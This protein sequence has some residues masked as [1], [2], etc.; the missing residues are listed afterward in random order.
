ML[1]EAERDDYDKAKS[2]LKNRFKSVDIAELRGLE[3]H[4]KQQESE[5]VEEL[6]ME[7]QRLGNLAF[8]TL[9]GQERDTFLSGPTGAL[10]A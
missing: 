10:E 8:P 6:G 3:F 1:P 5:T 2:A 9:H 4:H 7:L